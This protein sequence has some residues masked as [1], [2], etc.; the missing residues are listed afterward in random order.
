MNA[1]PA[2]RDLLVLRDVRHVYGD[3]GG[4]VE[5]LRGISLAVGAGEF[6]ALVGQSGSGKS[7]LL[8]VMGAM[9]RPRAGEVWLG[10]RDVARLDDEARTEIRRREVGFV[11]QFFN[12]LPTLDLRE[13][14]MLPALL[15]GVNAVAARR[16]ADELLA[17][18][19][20]AGLA[21]RRATALSGGERQRG[22]IA[23]ALVNDAPLLLADEPTGNLDS[24]TGADIV[25]LLRGLPA[26]RG[27]TV[28]L[29][30][31]SPELA[32]AADRVVTMRD[33]RIERVS[34][35]SAAPPP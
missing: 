35:A 28:V 30:T 20:L 6:V 25:R 21:G 11:F 17:A 22:A 1:A 13:N 4:E 31:H 8:H 10:G 3:E 9:D 12:L 19:G 24:A 2:R 23:R 16:R 34:P 5:A 33:G 7:T 27:T 18:V 32:Q 26:A 15:A 29:A 14:V